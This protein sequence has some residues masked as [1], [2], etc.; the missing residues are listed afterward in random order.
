MIRID[1]IRQNTR[2]PDKSRRHPS[3]A[4]C[5]LAGHRFEAQGRVLVYKL[6]TLLWLH[7][8]ART[9]FEIWDDRSPFGNPGELAMTGRVRS[10]APQDRA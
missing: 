8:H 6:S 5:E 2:H 4:S 9:D 10:W 7:G 3:Q 1:M